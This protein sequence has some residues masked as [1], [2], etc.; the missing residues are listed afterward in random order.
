M[1]KA[2]ILNIYG[3]DNNRKQTAL[4]CFV[5]DINLTSPVGA[6]RNYDQS[7]ATFSSL[8]I[9][10]K[11]FQNGNAEQIIVINVIPEI[12]LGTLV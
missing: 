10:Q 7:G 6:G 12:K 9:F 1:N 4:A 5:F 8:G 3:G 2:N 11:A